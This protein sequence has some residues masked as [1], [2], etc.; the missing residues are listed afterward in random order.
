MAGLFCR[1]ACTRAFW[2]SDKDNDMGAL[3]SPHRRD[4]AS[5]LEW[6]G[7]FLTLYGWMLLVKCAVSLLLPQVG[8]RSMAVAQ[9]G[10]ATFFA[11]GILL[12]CIGLS[13]AAALIWS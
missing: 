4:T 12:V 11:G 6:P 13:S 1:F 9:R 2:R 5:D 3:A 7:H 8:L 10:P